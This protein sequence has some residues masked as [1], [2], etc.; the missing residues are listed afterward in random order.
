LEEKIMKKSI[1]ILFGLLIVASMVLTA[2]APQVQEVVKTVV[3][4]QEVMVEG[5]T[6]IETVIETVVVTPEPVAEETKPVTFNYNFGTEPPSLDPSLATDTTSIAV[7][8]NIFVGLTLIDAITNEP[9][10]YLATEWEVGTDA[11]GFQTWTFKLRD[12]IPWVNYNPATGETTQA[13]DADG[14][15]R[16]VNANDVVY[17]VKRTLT[18]DTGSDYSYV[19]YII[20]NAQAFNNGEEGVTVDDVGVAALDDWT[21]QFTLQNPAGYFPAI[22]SMWVAMPMPQWA[23]E[24]ETYGSKW[25]EAGL[26]VTNGPYVVEEWIHGGSLVLVKNPLWINAADVQIERIEG[27]MI[28]E[29]STE[30][31]LYENNELDYSDVPLPEMDRVKSD[32]VLSADYYQAP[33]ACTYY[34]GFTN[35][36]PPFDDVRV[37]RAFSQAIDR[38][39]LIDNV[40]KGGQL[41]A[42]SFAPPGIFGA[43]PPGEVGLGTDPAAAKAALDEYLAEKGMTLDDFN[44]MG[45]TL[46]HNTS[47]GHARIAAA[48]QQMWKDTLGVDVKVENQE[49]GVYLNTVDNQTPI[50][51]MPHIWRLGWCADYPDENNWVHEVFNATAGDN[52]LRRNCSDAVCTETTNSEYDELTYQ[53]QAESDPAVRAELYREAERILAE[54]ETAYAP[55]YHYTTVGVAKPWLTRNYPSVAPLDFFNWKIDWE[56]KL[57]ATGQ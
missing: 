33:T 28:Q 44:A 24:D 7:V 14:N 2:C 51:D 15:P 22:A 54:V 57:A 41:P 48:I 20:K 27:L 31:A 45:I 13:V 36:K 47:E 21:V 55:I 38:Q 37:R 32:P 35:T 39:S 4:T 49:W 3:V 53:A 8:G 42:T 17:G 18:P 43:P 23:I 46:M 50:A 52:N 25:T 56:A 26:I 16:F 9:M 40:L 34:Y 5:E 12:D 29:D 10:P 30:F 6:V 19:L 1:T 11:E